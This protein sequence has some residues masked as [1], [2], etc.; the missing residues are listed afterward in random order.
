[1]EQIV[2][3]DDWPTYLPSLVSIP[4]KVLKDSQNDLLPFSGRIFSHLLVGGHLRQLCTLTSLHDSSCLG[5]I[6]KLCKEAKICLICWTYLRNGIFLK[7]TTLT[8]VLTCGDPDHGVPKCPTPIMHKRIDQA[9]FKLSQGGGVH[10]GPWQPWWLI[11][12]WFRLWTLW[13]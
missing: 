7:N 3:A 11:C 13:R 1:M 9:M 4:F 8:H 5:G 10:G 6:E 12:Q 2:G